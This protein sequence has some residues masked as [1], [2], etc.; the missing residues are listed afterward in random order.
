MVGVVEISATKKM[1]QLRGSNSTW[2]QAVDRNTA[3]AFNQCFHEIIDRPKVIELTF[4]TRIR[5][6]TSDDASANDRCERVVAQAFR[7]VRL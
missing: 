4:G 3:E 5:L 1:L 6:V 2:I 7:V